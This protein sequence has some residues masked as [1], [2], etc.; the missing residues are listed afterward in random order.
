MKK[1]LFLISVVFLTIPIITAQTTNDVLNLLIAN[2]TITQAQADS[3][4]AEAAIKQ[5]ETDANKKTFSVTTSKPIQ[6]SGYAQMRY[7]NLDEKHKI[8]G[9]DIRRA[10]I[11]LKGAISPY[12]NVRFQVDLAGTAPKL[13]DAYGEC[14]LADY[15]NLTMGQFKIPFSM[16]NLAS[17]SKLEMIDRSQVVEALV[18]RGKDVIGNQNGRDIGIQASGSVVKFNDRYLFDYF[19]GVFN[20]SGINIGDK[21]EAKS[22]VSRLVFHPLKGIDVGC[23]YYNGWDNFG[24][25]PKD[26]TRTRKG[27]ELKYDLKQYSIKW[28]YIE[29]KDGDIERSGWYVQSGYFVIPQ[30]LQFVVK[31]DT[32]DPVYN[33]TD[34]YSMNYTIVA[35]YAFNN[36]SKIQFGYIIRN[37]QGPFINNNI[38]TIQFQIGF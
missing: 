30:K 38:G 13:L 16:E 25:T 28:E 34:D 4:R 9:F 24:S 36:F 23:S 2:K 14:K 35:N 31:L 6:L 12:W 33:K 3:I 11:D 37:E 15:F 1:I 26:Q 5:Q 21:N 19:M 27:Y 17:S 20:G 22:F 32:F 29:G 18:A 8:D 10:R 7:Q